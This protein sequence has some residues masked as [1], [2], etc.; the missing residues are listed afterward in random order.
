MI[1]YGVARVP[2]QAGS[3]ESTTAD[4]ADEAS[5]PVAQDLQPLGPP[6]ALIEVQEPVAV[7]G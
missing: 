5:S 4:P 1:R 6:T 7:A 3:S 2:M